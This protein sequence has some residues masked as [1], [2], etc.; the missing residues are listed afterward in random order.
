MERCTVEDERA[1]EPMVRRVSTARRWAEYLVAILAGNVV[2]LFIE[3]NLPVPLRHQMFRVD[4]GL[5]IDF[6]ICVAV[7]GLVRLAG[8]RGDIRR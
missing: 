3:P 2:Y 5:G 8:G 6:L 7:Y 1:N 4:V